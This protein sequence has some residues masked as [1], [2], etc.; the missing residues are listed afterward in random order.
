MKVICSVFASVTIACFIAG[1]GS[2]VA[3]GTSMDRQQKYG[4]LAIV[5]AP[6]G[7][8]NPAYVPM[9]LK[10]AQSRIFPLNFLQKVECLPDVSIDTTS[11][12]PAVMLDDFSDY[13]AVVVLVYSYGEGH[14]YLDCYMTDTMTGEQ[15]WHY[16]FDAPDPAIKDR[17]C[18][19]GLYVPAVIKKEFYGL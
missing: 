13:D 19:Q 8:A 3:S 14:V 9:I 16:Q 17:L 5:C 18:S 11:T 4:R 1:C 10:E 12:P 2:E 7:Q 15:I 6:A